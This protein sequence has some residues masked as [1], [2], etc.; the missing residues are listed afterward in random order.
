MGP[1]KKPSPIVRS[2]PKGNFETATRQA[3][4]APRPDL[5][6]DPVFVKES[7]LKKG[8][9]IVRPGNGPL[10]YMGRESQSVGGMAAINVMTFVDVSRPSSS[11]VIK[12]PSAKFP[13]TKIRKPVSVEIMDQALNLMETIKS[14]PPSIAVYK[15]AYFEEGLSSPRLEHIVSVLAEILKGRTR[16]YTQ[17]ESEA[18]DKAAHLLA[19]EYAVVKQ[20]GYEQAMGVIEEL[21]GKPS[22]DQLS[23]YGESPM[24]IPPEPWRP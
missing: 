13:Q 22:L 2:N 12:I 23:G 19:A 6:P 3:K 10:R 5:L 21:M 15:A 1:A 20:T 4:W 24:D 18:A 7:E 14:V 11:A 9:M 16:E 8:D 17:I